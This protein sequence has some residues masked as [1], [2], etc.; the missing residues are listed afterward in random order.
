MPPNLIT[1]R[2]SEMNRETLIELA[3]KEKW[4][5][6]MRLGDYD[7]GSWVYDNN[8]PSNYHLYPTFQFLNELNIEDVICLDIGT[9]DGMGA[10]SLAARGA[11]HVDATCQYDL[12]RFRIARALTGYQ[13]VAYHPKTD[14]ALIHLTFMP[15]KY[16]LVLMT[17]MLHH[18]LSPIQGVLEARRNLKMGGYLIVEALIREGGAAD[19]KLNTAL[20]DP[21]YGC[22]TIWISSVDGIKEI[23]RLSSL[24]P[25]AQI[26]LIGGKE[27][28]ESN[29]DR[30]TI[31]AQAVSREQ[32]Q[33]KNLKLIEF[34][35]QI[36][37]I[38]GYSYIDFEN[39][40]YFPSKYI[41]SK[42]SIHPYRNLH[43]RSHPPHDPMQPASSR[44]I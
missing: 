7:T 12:D 37:T 30:V 5:H 24:N 26:H 35:N 27:A 36:Q 40:S 18:L 13:N 23:L 6:N 39:S 10:F 22:P 3:R 44:N 29:Y 17:A 9:F 28:R 2:F 1:D 19:F 4:F 34:H 41:D 25:V 20:D 16:D 8:L 11:A 21:V 15:A 33:G 32:I 38:E 31:L 14:I 42:N 43:I